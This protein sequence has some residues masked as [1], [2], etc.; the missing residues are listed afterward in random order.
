MAAIMTLL[1]YGVFDQL[2]ALPWPPTLLG[3][4]LPVLKAY[5]PSV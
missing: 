2:L 4:W 1:I 3:Q 5:I